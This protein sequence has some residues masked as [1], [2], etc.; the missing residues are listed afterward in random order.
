LVRAQPGQYTLGLIPI[1]M[2]H[3]V[4]ARAAGLATLAC[5]AVL[6]VA[7][8]MMERGVSLFEYQETLAVR[9]EAI[10]FNGPVLWLFYAF[11]T[12]HTSRLAKELQRTND[13]LNAALAASR[14]AEREQEATV[15][16]LCHELRS[17]LN[18][19]ALGVD[20]LAADPKVA[21]SDVVAIVQSQLQNVQQCLD[22][23][24]LVSGTGSTLRLAVP[25]SVTR[26][27]SITSASDRGAS[28]DQSPVPSSTR[29]RAVDS[30]VAVQPA[31][32][33]RLVMHATEQRT[34]RSRAASP[35]NVRVAIPQPNVSSGCGPPKAA[36]QRLTV[37]VCVRVL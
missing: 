34:R 11:G 9:H 36:L 18:C 5:F 3:F 33:L 26:P 25:S 12:L 2:L 16:F 10:L 22:D 29:S 6:I 35:G 37:P 23:L 30:V 7:Y 4:N 19:V 13:A 17:P 15:R 31:E 32:I 20:E 21:A 27:L 14:A 28:N 1:G 8:V 24:L